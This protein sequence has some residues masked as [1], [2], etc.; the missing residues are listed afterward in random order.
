MDRLVVSSVRS[1][2]VLDTV[3][4]VDGVLAYDTGKARDL[5]EAPR[6][7]K[8]DLTDAQLLAMRSNWSNGYI[9]IRPAD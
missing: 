5:V 3:T 4:L 6:I 8:P 7:A 2:R 9:Q 1:G